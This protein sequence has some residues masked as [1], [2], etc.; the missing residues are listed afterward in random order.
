ML[1]GMNTPQKEVWV[2][3]S[4]NRLRVAVAQGVGGTFDVVQPANL[5]V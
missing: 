4:L 3:E 2:D 5:K 1:V